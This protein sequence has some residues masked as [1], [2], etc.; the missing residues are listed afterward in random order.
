[1]AATHDRPTSLGT[2]SD[3]VLTCAG[4][5]GTIRWRPGQRLEQLFERRCDR[6]R[7]HGWGQHLAVDALDWS[8]S[9]QELDE[10]ANQLARFLVGQGLRPGDRVG[11]LSDRAVDGYVGMLAALKARAAYVP[12]DAGLPPDRLSYIVSDAGVRVVLTRSYLAARVAALGN[13]VTP[14]DLDEAESLIA[15]QRPDRLGRAEAGDPV[16]D[17]CY[18]IYTSGSTGRPKGVAIGHASICNFVRVAAEVYGIAYDD[19]VYQGMTI[20][21]DFSVEEIWVPWIAGATL[22]PKP[23][24]DRLLGRELHT[25]LTDRQVTA[26]CCVPTLLATL[27]EDLPG[28]R[29][30]LVSGESCPQ[31]LVTRWH[32]PGRRFLNVYGPTEATVTAT[33]T[34]VHPGRPVTI[35]VPLPTYSVVVLDPDSDTAL[36]PGAM[37]EIGIAGV[38]LARGYLN[39]PDLTERAFVPDF[40]GIPD[41][42]PGRIY[43]TGDLGRVNAEGEIEHHG[44]IDTQVKIRGYRIELTE[45]ESVL[46][47]APGIAQAVVSTYRPEPDVVEL[48]AYYSPRRDAPAVDADRVYAELRRQLPG[49][50]VPAY[51]EQLPVIPMLPSGK[52]DR[53]GLPAPRGRR[54]LASPGDHAA[55]ATQTE[56]DL[57]EV[58]ARALG[59]ER[60]PVDGHFFDDLGASSLLMARFSAAIRERPNLPPVSLKDIYLHP[61]VRRLAAAIE[62]PAPAGEP[63]PTVPSHPVPPVTGRPRYFLCGAL[64]LLAFAVY[65]AGV[66]LAVDAGSS[67]AMAGR[68]ALG[69]Y[70]RLVAFGGGGLLVLGVLP[71]IAK[72]ILV[73]RWKPRR[74]RAWSLAYVRFWIV[75][76]MIVANPMARMFVGT[77]LY[78]Q[79]L[80]AL[81]ARIGPGVAIFT[82]H[83]PV[84]T[85]LLTIGAG[86]VIRKDTFISGYRA[87]AGVIETGAITLGP[88]AF[89]GER[90]VID[91]NTAVGDGAQLGHASGLLAGQ[92]V[93]AGACWHGSPAQPAEA[94]WDY[95]TVPPARCGAL[96]R[97]GY[98]ATRLLLVLAVA[99]P[100]T[101]AAASLLLSRPSLLGRPLGPLDPTG[102]ALYS[103]AVAIAAVA[104]FGA[105]AAGLVLVG[106][107]P[108]LLGRALKPGKTYPLY[109]L[110]HGLQR[111]VSRW[112]NIPFFTALFGDSSAIV[113]YLSLLGYRLAPVEQTGSN[114]GMEVKH[115]MPRLVVVGTGTMVSDGLSIMNAEF[116]SSSFRVRPVTIGSRNFVGNGIA[117]PAGGRTGDNCLLATKVMIPVGGP[118]REGVGL[119]GSP[120]FEIPRTVRSDHQFDHLSTMRRRRHRLKAKNRHNAATVGEHLLVRWLY[121]CGLV[122]VALLPS[123]A[124]IV[125]FGGAIT[126]DALATAALALLDI[127]W[128]IGLFVLVE[129]VVTGFRPLQPR[130]CSIYQPAFWEHERFWKVP[131]VAYIQMFNGTPFKSVV[132]R[133]LGVRV[134]RRVLDDGCSIVERTLVRIGSEC[135]LNAGSILQSHSLEDGTFKSDH[136]TI[137]DR[138]TIGTGAFVHYGI[139]M[140]DDAVL[141]ADAFLMKGEHVPPGSCWRGNPA[142]DT[143][144][145]RTPHATIAPSPATADTAS[146][147]PAVPAA[148]RAAEPGGPVTVGAAPGRPATAVRAPTPSVDRAGD[149]VPTGAA[150][151][152][153]FA[154][155]PASPP[156][157]RRDRPR[158]GPP[159]AQP[160]LYAPRHSVSPGAPGSPAQPRGH[161]P[162]GIPANR[163]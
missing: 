104:F 32:R 6:L 54:H 144:A 31:D 12:L 142:A 146:S 115:E 67:W 139:T 131:S 18:V 136:I 155:D 125:P 20:A 16:D 80:R 113:R 87:R 126:S 97:A 134:G 81:G 141:D 99:G 21:F 14:L 83:V 121:V 35:G 109:G 41:N 147:L 3:R 96:R 160:P 89:V 42:P 145:A 40:L 65:L 15:A 77:P 70:A 158:P 66:S 46:L 49:Y 36:P 57:A 119:L 19:R 135:T 43:R 56:R 76:T 93:P 25:F 10:L 28:L 159:P 71:V 11:L 34:V 130:F 52:A 162:A 69:I 132:W 112:S 86:S 48:A 62:Q 13:A 24:G 163:M 133:L 2:L 105:I 153:V 156:A 17:L 33:W 37:G 100:V 84:C 23:D 106:T 95:R 82:Q 47:Q 55:P 74:I 30:L 128:T 148:V 108:R 140:G 63:P 91:I 61:T 68:G 92:A 88:G 111:T 90:T 8:L 149:R 118:V 5:D 60:V 161:E 137:G 116:S 45:I 127:A 152:A 138:C 4:Y 120:C 72:W 44:R 114:F 143:L 102:P 50:M 26:L 27:D 1:V 94:G 107:V 51:L 123:G 154:E 39:R 122:L 73:G 53:A 150:W 29:F 117:Y 103:E 22:V 129:R 79:Y 78:V 151:A 58:L 124:A 38:G 110:R 7:Q 85:D 64:Q 59:A 98:S 75:K 157:P 9:Y 101:A